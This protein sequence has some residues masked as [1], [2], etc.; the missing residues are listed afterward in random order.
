MDTGI[1]RIIPLGGLGEIG[2]NMMVFEYDDTMIVIDVGLMFPEN[3]M[4][5]IDII[6]PDFTYVIERAERLKAI[7][8]THGHE[9]HIG[10]LP[11]LL[12][13]V[14]A[15]VYAT[16]LTRGLIEVKLREGG[17]RDADLRPINPGD[18]IE[19]GPFGI[20]F[21]H[22][23][24]SIPDGVG[25]GIQ[26]P[27]GLVVHTGD[28]KLDHSPVDGE[29]TDFAKLA[30]LGGR[31][32][33]LL[34][35]DSTNAESA[36][37]T[38][39][40]QVLGET[41]A[42]IFAGSQGRVIVATFASNISRISQV[43][44]TSTRF[45]RKVGIVGRSM[46]SNVRI[47]RKLGYLDVPDDVLLSLE[48][49]EVLPD[50]QVTLLCTG[51]QGEPTSALVRMGQGQL[52]SISVTPGDTVIV[53]ATPIPGNEEFVNRTLD[54]LFRLRAN[55]YYDEVLDVHV[56]GHAAQE[57][58]KMML[59]LIQPE[60]FVPIHGEYRHLVLHGKLAQL[61]GVDP[62]RIFVL[63][64]GDVLELDAEGARMAEA[65]SE[66]HVV[67][68]GRAVKDSDQTIMDERQILAR[69]GFLVVSVTLDKYTGSLVG[70]PQF[71]TRGFIYAAESADLLEQAKAEVA[72]V[73]NGGG[74]RGEI[75]DRLSSVLGRFA[76]E[77]TGRRPIVIP[78]VN[79]V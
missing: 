55:V 39:S 44:A 37:Y 38:P 20:E 76:H 59:N 48:Q 45:G 30:E 40:E 52:R 70:D 31:G 41:L 62:A 75:A 6:I 29:R 79:R 18:R 66:G 61:C 71:A 26:T 8:I 21:F 23:C 1:L 9:D 14:N 15:P 34:L 57:E 13:R 65:V 73:I 22:V 25:M 67:V 74:S 7:I 54:N 60:Y 51:S 46:V 33:R 56:S 2:R 10:A 16:A 17:V 24:H 36:G 32:V 64:T 58:Q 27:V 78:L 5:G 68:D 42:R 43:I 69:N 53:S 47:A 35:S 49:I 63:E 11:Y 72:R 19:V 77:A 4:L 28:F 3:D 50:S 12:A